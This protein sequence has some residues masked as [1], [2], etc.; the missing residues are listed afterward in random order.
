MVYSDCFSEY[1]Y[2]FDN[3]FTGTIPTQ[4]GSMTSLSEFIGRRVPLS[5]FLLPSALMNSLLVCFSVSQRR[6]GSIT[7]CLQA[8]SLVQSILLLA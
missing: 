3:R 6:R 1:L 4:F 5:F 2:L 7:I 8:T